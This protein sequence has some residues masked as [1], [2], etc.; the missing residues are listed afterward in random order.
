MLARKHE[1]RIVKLDVSEPFPAF[2]AQC[3]CKCEGKFHTLDEAAGWLKVHVEKHSDEGPQPPP[4]TEVTVD[5]SFKKP[6]AKP[7][8]KPVVAPVAKPFFP[9]VEPVTSGK[10]N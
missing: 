4:E 2:F 1:T 3:T 8:V 7:A 5:Q 9:A 6:A 10:E